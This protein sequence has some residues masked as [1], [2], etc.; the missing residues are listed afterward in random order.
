MIAV[1]PTRLPVPERPERT[2][3]QRCE[4]SAASR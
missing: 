2:V 1:D 3:P 4:Q